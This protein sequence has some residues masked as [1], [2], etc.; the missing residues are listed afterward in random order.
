MMKEQSAA[1]SRRGFLAGVGSVV[2]AGLLAG[3]SSLDE[4]LSFEAQ[5]ATVPPAVLEQTGY[6][7]DTVVPQTIQQSF[8]VAGISQTVVVTNWQAE[9]SKSV[10]LPGID[11]PGQ[12]P[13]ALFSLL[14]TPRVD[15]L[16]RSFNPVGGWS[17]E[18]IATEIQAQYDGLEGLEPHGSSTI[19]ILGQSTTVTMFKG[20]GR[21]GLPIDIELT[22]HISEAVEAG[23][24]FVIALCGYPAATDD[25]EETHVQ[26]LLESVQ[27]G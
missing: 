6:R 13:L 5:P 24:D 20:D 10:S 18:E 14:A 7:E 16:G 23:D 25:I 27:H 21:F 4:A 9:Y 19:E 26:T 15:L 2:T 1:S 17:A 12:Q 11:L 3:C 8:N 22:I